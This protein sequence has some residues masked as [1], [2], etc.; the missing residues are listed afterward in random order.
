MYAC[1]MFID[2]RLHRIPK[3]ACEGYRRLPAK[4]TVGC[5]PR[6]PKAACV[7]CRRVPKAAFDS[8]LM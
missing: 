4:A 7:C 8:L 6:V 3:A 2:S 5:L 1:H